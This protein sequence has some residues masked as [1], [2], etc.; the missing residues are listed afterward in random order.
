MNDQALVELK[1][2]A[3]F[4]ISTPER[5]AEA[6]LFVKNLESFAEEVKVKVKERATEVMDRENKDL[7]TY[8][9]TDPVSGEVREW[10]MRRSY[11]TETKEYRAENVFKAFGPETALQFLSVS[12]MKLEAFLKKASAKGEI[13]MAQVDAAVSDPILKKRKGAGVVL[14]EVKP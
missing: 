1:E 14:R 4:Y 6:L 5:A 7:I 10:E 11:D 8:R 9:I 2:R 13:T 12:K 3:R